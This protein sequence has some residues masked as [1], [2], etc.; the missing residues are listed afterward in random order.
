M[1]EEIIQCIEKPDKLDELEDL[2][3][4]IKRLNDKV[5]VTVYRKSEDKIIIIT[6]FK[7]SKIR[8]YLP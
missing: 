4:C 8:K 1:K 3:R 5:L 6:A 7:T 2:Y